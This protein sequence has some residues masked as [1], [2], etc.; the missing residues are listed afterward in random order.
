M[1]ELDRR[2][3]GDRQGKGCRDQQQAEKSLFACRPTRAS[4][5]CSSP[6]LLI[7]PHPARAIQEDGCCCCAA[8]AVSLLREGKREEV[9]PDQSEDLSQCLK[10][11]QLGGFNHVV[12]LAPRML[13]VRQRRTLC[14]G[15]LV[16]GKALLQLQ[17]TWPRVQWLPAPPHD[18]DE[19]VL[20]LPGSRARPG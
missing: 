4:V 5:A 12:A 1:C 16:V 11:G 15:V 18:G 20:P 6:Y 7:I 10:K 13:Q 17:A 14:R 2:V 9:E 19:A 8:E 3:K